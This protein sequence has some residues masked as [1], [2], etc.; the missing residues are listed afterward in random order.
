MSLEGGFDELPE[1]FSAAAS[2]VSSA[3]TRASNSTHREQ[4]LSC[5]DP[6]IVAAR[7]PNH[8]EIHQDQSKSVDGY[9]SHPPG[10][11]LT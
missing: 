11:V 6:A 3:A 7:I 4:T 5:F 2:C 9:G 8:P 1:F 10:V